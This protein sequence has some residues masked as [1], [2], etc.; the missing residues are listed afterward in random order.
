MF[1]DDA[2]GLVIDLG[3]NNSYSGFIGE[4]TPSYTCDSNFLLK[5]GNSSTSNFWIPKNS[6]FKQYFQNGK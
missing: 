3:H 4:E 6:M 1:C 2:N 5:P